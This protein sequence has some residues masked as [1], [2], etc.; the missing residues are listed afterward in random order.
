MERLLV[1]N[2]KDRASCDQ[3]VKKLKRLREA[4]HGDDGVAFDTDEW[5]DP[6][7][8]ITVRPY[9]WDSSSGECY[10]VDYDKELLISQA[11]G[12]FSSN[13]PTSSL[14][15]VVG[16]ALINEMPSVHEGLIATANEAPPQEMQPKVTPGPSNPNAATN[17]IGDE[18]ASQTTGTL[19]DL[20]DARDN[21]QMKARQLGGTRTRGLKDLL[22][23]CFCCWK[24]RL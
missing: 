11:E 5:P 17:P 13:R 19:L 12:L 24:R 2:P 14:V 23:S 20:S 3:L 18:T 7:R 22:E 16:L 4:L 1:P 21:P 15:D 9:I 6:R 10:D 8:P